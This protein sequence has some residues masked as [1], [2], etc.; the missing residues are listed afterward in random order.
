MPN[1]KDLIELACLKNVPN[2]RPTHFAPA[3]PRNGGALSNT[4]GRA[5]GIYV[6][7]ETRIRGIGM[8]KANSF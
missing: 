3:L 6:P 7:T 8:T 1:A 5:S 2:G 4:V